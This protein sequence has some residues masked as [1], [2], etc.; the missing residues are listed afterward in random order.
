VPR[1]VIDLHYGWRRKLESGVIIAAAIVA[2]WLLIGN[3]GA[4]LLGLWSLQFWPRRN[5][6][7][8][9]I[10]PERVRWGRL[11]Q[12]RIS[13]ARG[14]QVQAIFRGEISDRDYAAVARLLKDGIRKRE[15]RTRAFG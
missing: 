14:F 8:V 15:H 6:E 3:T 9:V 1:L 4:V 7:R 10:D 5:G 2:G 11:H 13:Y 12:S